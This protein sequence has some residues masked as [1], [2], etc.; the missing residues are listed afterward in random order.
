DLTAWQADC[1]VNDISELRQKVCQLLKLES[2]KP[3]VL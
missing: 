2:E 1:I 3:V